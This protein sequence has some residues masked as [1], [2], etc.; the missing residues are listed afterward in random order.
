MKKQRVVTVTMDI[1][2][3]THEG[4][5]SLNVTENGKEKTEFSLSEA[6]TT[7]SAL[8]WA[9]SRMLENMR[10]QALELDREFP[11]SNTKEEK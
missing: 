1:D 4:I 6:L 9:G 11:E 7:V 5:L 10:E 2:M 3:E 8:S